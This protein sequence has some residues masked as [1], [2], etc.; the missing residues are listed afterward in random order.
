MKS[1]EKQREARKE[2]GDPGNSHSRAASGTPCDFRRSACLFP[3]QVAAGSG[4]R[5]G[6]RGET[7]NVLHREAI[8]RKSSQ[9]AKRYLTGSSRPAATECCSGYCAGSGCALNS[10]P[11]LRDSA[12]GY[13]VSGLRVTECRC[14][15]H[16]IRLNRRPQA[17]CSETTLPLLMLGLPPKTLPRG[18]A[19]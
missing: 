12:A 17:A 6:F 19:P 15:A 8:K 14:F 5:Q 2:S 13:G 1:D 16:H 18:P 4:P 11:S 3:P 7:P 9:G 10:I